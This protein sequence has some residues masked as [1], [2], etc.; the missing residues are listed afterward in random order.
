MGCFF[1]YLQ[2][3]YSKIYEYQIKLLQ[4]NQKISVL[5]TSVFLL[6]DFAP[7]KFFKFIKT[8]KNDLLID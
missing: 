7:S 3:E 5:N 4:N 2:F 6:F 8:H 1:A